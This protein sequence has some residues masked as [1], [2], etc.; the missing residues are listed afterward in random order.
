MTDVENRRNLGLS[1]AIQL[2]I[3]TTFIGIQ[4]FLGH[5]FCVESPYC[6]NISVKL[7]LVNLFVSIS[8]G[9]VVT[10]ALVVT[11]E[12]DITCKSKAKKVRTWDRIHNVHM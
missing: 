8:S 3:L 9:W 1:C 10:G 12:S 7:F 11:N 2:L 6:I 5:G 4:H